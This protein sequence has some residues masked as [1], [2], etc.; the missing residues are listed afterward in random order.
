MEQTIKNYQEGFAKGAA[1]IKYGEFQKFKREA[2]KA[3][4]LHARIQ[5]YNYRD[6]KVE[7]KASKAAALE[8]VFKKY[9]ITEIWGKA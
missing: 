7:P 1:Q 8:E 6:G 4:G 9:G 2:M 3:L 5:F